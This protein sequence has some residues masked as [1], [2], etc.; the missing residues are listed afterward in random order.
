MKRMHYQI[1]KYTYQALLV[2]AILVLMACQGN[3]QKEVKTNRE[4]KP[5][6]DTEAIVLGADR[7][8]QY[9]PLL[10]KKRVGMTI[11]NTSVIDGKLTMDTLIAMGIRVV[12]G[13]GPEHGF[14]GKASAGAE[15]N[16][17]VDEK[18]GVPLVSLYGQKYKPTKEDM[19]G[20]DV[21]VFDMQ[22]VGTRFY[23][24]LSTLH[25]IMEACAENGVELIILDRPNP[26]DG[27][28]DG[29]VLEKGFES[30]IGMH[31]IPITHGLTFGE[32]ANMINDQGWLANGIK[33]KVK[34][35]AMLHYHHGKKYKLPI[36]P[37]P[38][39]NTQ[40]AILLYPSTCLFEG[41]AISEGRGTMYAFSILGSP[42]LKGKY[43]FAYTPKAIPGMAEKPKYLG[44]TCYG[45]D[46]RSYDTDGFIESGRLNISWLKELY[47]AYPDKSAFFRDSFKRL[48][49]TDKLAQQ[50]KDGLSVEE[51]QKSWEPALAAYKEM[52]KKYLIYK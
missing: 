52:R 45:L 27:Y 1:S 30:F 49:G 36:P 16:D 18:T 51:I 24:Y 10:K 39:L 2:V 12:R 9:L 31:P 20:L 50:I 21:M 17:E 43:E 46:L 5:E 22:D 29:P 13:F 48:A 33:C 41:T 15:I 34:V 25:Y 35:I 11:N 8:D 44:E 42:G 6:L 19:K 38:N 26:N 7:L 23:T 28:I 3:T 37:S 32:Y 47:D 40:Q 4:N 14:R